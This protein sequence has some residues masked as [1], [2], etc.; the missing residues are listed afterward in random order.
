MRVCTRA[1]PDICLSHRKSTTKI[2]VFLCVSLQ[3]TAF[4]CAQHNA[5]YCTT[6]TQ[7]ANHV[8]NSFI[9]LSFSIEIY[10]QRRE[11]EEGRE[12][13]VQFVA[14]ISHLIHFTSILPT[15]VYPQCY[16]L[17]NSQFI[18]CSTAG[19]SLCFHCKR[20]QT[21]HKCK[22]KKRNETLPKI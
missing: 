16:L 6:P 11:R 17:S 3:H 18:T 15:I 20:V 12:S 5:M 19:H 1:Y 2:E 22:G 9:H 8:Y 10:A 13:T 4:L 21:T 14:A 7:T